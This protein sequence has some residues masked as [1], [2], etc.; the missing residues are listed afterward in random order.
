MSKHGMTTRQEDRAYSFH[1]VKPIKTEYNYCG[2][3]MAP[4]VIGG[5]IIFLPC[6]Y[7]RPMQ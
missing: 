7:G 2:I 6:S 1:Y 5:A 4:Y 3:I